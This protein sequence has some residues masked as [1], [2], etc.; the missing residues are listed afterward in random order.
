MKFEFHYLYHNIIVDDEKICNFKIEN[1]N[2]NLEIKKIIIIIR[3]V[4]ME[5][6]FG[7]TTKTWPRIGSLL[8]TH[9]R[10]PKKKKKRFL[11]AGPQTFV[12]L[13]KPLFYPKKRKGQD[14][15][16]KAARDWLYFV[17]HKIG[18]KQKI[19]SG[20]SSNSGQVS[21]LFLESFFLITIRKGS[22]GFGSL[23]QMRVFFWLW[24]S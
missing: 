6:Y 1:K 8:C 14:L 19:L 13:R 22:P 24:F 17:V 18:P 4:N 20:R 7:V 21:L 16:K 9:N 2:K 11:R 3:F 10:A 5:T 15:K 12:V 23:L